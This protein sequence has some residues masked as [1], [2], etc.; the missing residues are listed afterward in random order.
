MP[1]L[2]KHE[3]RWIGSLGL[4]ALLALGT[5]GCSRART[6][7]QVASDVQNRIRTDARM[8]MARVRVLVTGGVV[9]LS[10]YVTS[11]DQRAATVQDASLVKDVRLVIDNL[12][13]VEAQPQESQPREPQAKPSLTKPSLSKPKPTNFSLKVRLSPRKNRRLGSFELGSLD[14]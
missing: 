8:Q 6:N 13:V 3:V 11:N 9:T 12:R 14:R 1:K 4:L 5:F 10:G 7:V 2:A